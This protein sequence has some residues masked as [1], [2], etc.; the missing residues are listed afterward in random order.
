MNILPS[1]AQVGAPAAPEDFRQ[2]I[3]RA[4][5]VREARVGRVGMRRATIGE[6]AVISMLR[7]FRARCI[8]LQPDA[9]RRAPA[10]DQF[11]IRACFSLSID[12]ELKRLRKLCPNKI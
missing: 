8:D 6:V 1:H 4:G 12:H 11:K 5:K 9:R 10:R 3:V 7:S 2:N